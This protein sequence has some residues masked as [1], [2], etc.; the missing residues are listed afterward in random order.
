MQTQLPSNFPTHVH[1]K[2]AGAIVPV[3]YAEAIRALA[4]CRA[5]DEAKHYADKAD[6]LAAW[7]KIYRD[8]EVDS[9]SRRLKAYAYRRMGLLAEE[10]QP[11]KYNGKGAMP[12][13]LKKLI[14]AGLS[15]GQASKARRI[16]AVPAPIFEK[17]VSDANPP[18]INKLSAHGAGLSLHARSNCS[19]PAWRIAFSAA[20]H[21]GA[22]LNA[23]KFKVFCRKESALKIARG[24]RPDERRAAVALVSEIREWLDEFEASLPKAE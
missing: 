21:T 9:E 17:L 22:S 8:K 19:S 23:Y 15:E 14:E 7:A 1:Q 11:T 3:V 13:P 24:L 5:I 4:A 6:A 20:G 18:G 2:I 10:L 16:S 12:G